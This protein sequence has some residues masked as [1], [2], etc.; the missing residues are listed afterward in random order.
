VSNLN[1]IIFK[2]VM[3]NKK[4]NIKKIK[5]INKFRKKKKKKKKKKVHYLGL[6]FELDYIYKKKKIIIF[7]FSEAFDPVKLIL[8]GY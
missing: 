7:S 6:G 1:I 3:W 4:V 2:I 8:V 5:C